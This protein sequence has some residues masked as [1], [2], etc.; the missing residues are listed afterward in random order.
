MRK[1]KFLVLFTIAIISVNCKAQQLIDTQS[2]ITEY[3]NRIVGT[4]ISDE[5]NQYKRVFDQNG[6]LTDYVGTEVVETYNYE[7]VSQCGN[8]NG[9]GFFLKLIDEDGDR[10][11]FI[12]NSIN[13]NNNNKMSLTGMLRG[14]IQLYTK[15][16]KN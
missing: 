16:Q 13:D 7:I 8:V 15:Q 6:T 12:I 5:D 1:L 10:Y 11:C 3:E 4:W 2:R 14:R 9:Y